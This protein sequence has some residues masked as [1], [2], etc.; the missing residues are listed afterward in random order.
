MQRFHNKIGQISDD[1]DNLMSLIDK[2]L[3]N[4]NSGGADA[5]KY[6]ETIQC[7]NKIRDCLIVVTCKKDD[8]GC[9]CCSSGSINSCRESSGNVSG[10]DAASNSFMLKFDLNE[11]DSGVSTPISPGQVSQNMQHI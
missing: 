6:D 3:D 4:Y 7:L 5:V 11:Q 9:S 8:S 2:M 1:S 10:G